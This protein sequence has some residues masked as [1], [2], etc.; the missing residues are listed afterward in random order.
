MLAALA[1]VL[2]YHE[3]SLARWV[4][5]DIFISLRYAANLL[6]GNGLV[7]NAGERVEG[8]TDFLWLMILALFQKLGFDP[9]Q[10]AE[11]LGIAS[12]LG[13]LALLAWVSHRIAP[14]RM[15][16]VVPFA[17]L[18]LA[19]HYEAA[20]WATSGLETFFYTLLLVSGFVVY[21]FTSLRRSR[22]LVL[23]GLALALAFLTRPDAGLLVILAFL[24]L[25]GRAWLMGLPARAWAVEF[26]FFGLPMALLLVPYLVWKLSYYGGLLPNTYY[27]KSAGVSCFSQGFFYLW[28][29]FRCYVTS[30]L[31]LLAVPVILRLFFAGGPADPPEWRARVRAV[32]GREGVGAAVFGLAAVVV[33]LVLFVARVGGDFMYARFVVPALPVLYLL[34]EWS[35]PRLGG[36]SLAAAPVLFL[37]IPAFT[38]TVERGNR[39]RYLLKEEDGRITVREHHGILDEHFYYTGWI[40][41]DEQRR[42]GEAY[43]PCF[44]GLDVTVLLRGQACLGYY[45]GFRNCIDNNGLTDAFIARQPLAHR[46]RVGHEKSAPYDYLIKRKTNFVFRRT[47]YRNKPYR[48]ASFALPGGFYD[49]AEILTYD[50]RVLG[51]LKRRMGE[52]F[53]FTPFEDYLDAYLRDA[54]P[55]EPIEVVREDYREF[56]DYYFGRNPDPARERRFLARL[57]LAP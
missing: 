56:R 33:Y 4:C 55:I 47:P 37:L 17:S 40:S 3:A 53:Q 51:E 21:F 7:Y 43:A 52:R 42:M 57:A 13:V 9:V 48:M 18:V 8:Y 12:F 2:G 32:L 23:A 41:L 30:G 44:A 11:N 27:A 50:P 35:L 10:T 34:V 14:A 19:V 54:L 22:R 6:H 25:L 29:Y 16:W 46:G 1:L 36:R 20:V 28:T 45:A 49:R 5:D 26:G 39:E 15:R 24:F 31:F 38:F